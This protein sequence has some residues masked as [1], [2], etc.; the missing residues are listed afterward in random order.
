MKR[1]AIFLFLSLSV[2]TAFAQQFGYVVPSFPERFG[3]GIRKIVALG[4]DGS[5]RATELSRDGR[6]VESW[7]PLYVPNGDSIITR[8]NRET[9]TDSI[10]WIHGGKAELTEMLEYRDTSFS[11]LVKR[12]SGCRKGVLQQTHF[13]ISKADTTIW[14]T[15]DGTDSFKPKPFFH[16]YKKYAGGAVSQDY[17]PDSILIFSFRIVYDSK[18]EA[19]TIYKWGRYGVWHGCMGRRDTTEWRQVE[20]HQYEY[21]RRGGIVEDNIYYDGTLGQTTRYKLRY[22][23]GSRKHP[24]NKEDFYLHTAS[25]YFF[26][27][28]EGYIAHYGMLPRPA[29]Q[30]IASMGCGRSEV[31]K[32]VCTQNR[33]HSRPWPTEDRKV[34][35][36]HWWV[37]LADS[38]R[39]C[40]DRR[41]Q[42]QMVE[43]YGDGLK[44]RWISMIPEKA[45]APIKQECGTDQKYL[46]ERISKSDKHYRIYYWIETSGKRMMG[47][48]PS[49][50]YD[51]DWNVLRHCR[52]I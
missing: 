32:V 14:L 21:N 43:H 10:F 12:I 35:R 52:P 46:I 1:A 49:Y 8:R 15:V 37:V 18:G 7:W 23:M 48:P 22:Y 42:F 39:L 44:A 47:L 6:V 29:R 28:G 30:F 3:K 17:N 13:N 27:C 20:T 33:Y 24:A 2:A 25:N 16:I 19:D 41:G 34:P 9:L 38:T 45:L 26:K 40:F 11:D 5:R 50:M 36:R 31:S 4:E 51:K